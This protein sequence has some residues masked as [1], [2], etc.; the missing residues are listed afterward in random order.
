MKGSAD[1]PSRL[2]SIPLNLRVEYLALSVAQAKSSALQP[3]SAPV[4]F[5]NELEER[6][7]VANIQMGMYS[8]VEKEGKVEDEME[9]A[10]VLRKLEEKLWTITEVGISGLLTCQASFSG[11]LGSGKANIVLEPL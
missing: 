6:S 9:R 2:Y 7:E 11:S 8:E 1:L 5:V 3:K 10:D 4:D